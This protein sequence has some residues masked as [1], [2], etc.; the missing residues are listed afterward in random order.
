MGNKKINYK[1]FVSIGISFMGVGVVVMFAVNT[2][3]G[4]ALLVAGLGNLAIGLS[5]GKK[6]E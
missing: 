3:L 4:L 2:V 5:M 1:V 6:K